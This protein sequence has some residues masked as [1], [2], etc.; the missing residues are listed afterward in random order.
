MQGFL[1]EN[2]STENKPPLH[3]ICVDRTP[4]HILTE[5]VVWFCL[6]LFVTPET[7]LMGNLSYPKETWEG[8]RNLF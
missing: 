4:S 3:V 6:V 8:K 2:I 1:G 5:G 7:K